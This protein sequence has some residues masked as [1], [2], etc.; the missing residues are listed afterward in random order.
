MFTQEQRDRL[1]DRHRGRR[2]TRSDL[3]AAL[4]AQAPSVRGTFDKEDAATAMRQRLSAINDEI[5]R[6]QLAIDEQQELAIPIRQQ[7]FE[8]ETLLQRSSIP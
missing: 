4:V 2:L 3:A 8:I 7:L 5:E 1:L 6:L